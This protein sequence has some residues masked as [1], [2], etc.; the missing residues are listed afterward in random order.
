MYVRHFHNYQTD[1]FNYN[2]NSYLLHDI[3]MVLVFFFI[4][5]NNVRM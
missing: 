4:L 1:N 5:G 2:V 3:F